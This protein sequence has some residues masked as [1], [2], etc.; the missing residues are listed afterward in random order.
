MKNSVKQ[1][2]AII[3]FIT[4]NEGKSMLQAISHICTC[5]VSKNNKEDHDRSIVCTAADKKAHLE[6]KQ[7]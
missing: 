4:E 7:S 2:S 5:V 1:F 3:L 6:T